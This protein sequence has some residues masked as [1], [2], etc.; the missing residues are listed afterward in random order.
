[1]LQPSKLR[2]CLAS[3]PLWAAHVWEWTP[4]AAV[5]GMRTLLNLRYAPSSA[6]EPQQVG[7]FPPAAAFYVAHE[8]PFRCPPGAPTL[9]LARGLLPSSYRQH[10]TVVMAPKK[11]FA[12]FQPVWTVHTEQSYPAILSPFFRRGSESMSSS[13]ISYKASS[14]RINNFASPPPLSRRHPVVV[15]VAARGAHVIQRH[16][17]R[18]ISARRLRTTITHAHTELERTR[19]IHAA[20]FHTS[21]TIALIRSRP[22]EGSFALARA[23]GR[24]SLRPPLPPH[25]SC[26]N[27]IL[28]SRCLPERRR[29]PCS[30]NLGIR[31]HAS[32]GGW[33]P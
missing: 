4:A 21:E 8:H 32:L 13:F 14:V 23:V 17:L 18:V 9:Y 7:A 26:T 5:D 31:S 25:S 16:G 27:N 2:L 10:Y 12:Y 6:A 19:S 11:C 15:S 24:S 29:P 28:R 22:S 1:M 33:D 3:P 30:R 20:R